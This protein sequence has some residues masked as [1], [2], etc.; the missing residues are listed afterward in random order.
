MF[1][2]NCFLRIVFLI[3]SLNNI[4]NA[5]L[6][7]AKF[8][9]PKYEKSRI[10]FSDYNFDSFNELD[11]FL[12]VKLSLDFVET[13]LQDGI[14]LLSNDLFDQE[15]N[16][17][18]DVWYPSLSLSDNS[19]LYAQ[20]SDEDKSKVIVIGDLHGNYD[21]LSKIIQ[22]L[23][24]R[25]I[26]AQDL[27]IKDGYKIVTLGD[28][29]D[30]GSESLQTVMFLMIL[31]IINPQNYIMLK[32]NHETRK[33]IEDAFECIDMNDKISKKF[34]EHYDFIANVSRTLILNENERLT[35]KNIF[36]DFFDLLPIAYFLKVKDKVFMF[37]HAG[38]SDGFLFVD[39]VLHEFLQ[40][41]L[42][43]AK[44]E[45]DDNSDEIAYRKSLLW[46]DTLPS[47][48]FENKM[49]AKLAEQKKYIEDH[50]LAAKY[51]L[52]KPSKKFSKVD[53]KKEIKKYS[54]VLLDFKKI[55][56]NDG[57]VFDF[58]RNAYL[59]NDK[60]TS[61]LME[62]CGITVRLCGH[63]HALIKSILFPDDLWY[64]SINKITDGFMMMGSR[65]NPVFNLIS[66]EINQGS[67]IV[68][69]N[70]SYLELIVDQKDWYIWGNS[71]SE[72][73]ELFESK[74]VPYCYQL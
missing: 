31:K 4:V 55:S 71:L 7:E 18:N 50:L 38:F 62:N 68:K 64:E 57:L 49:K 59:F 19:F 13:I 47:F 61:Y 43:Y 42:R 26:L 56:I 58:S 63:D 9:D 2:R 51:F 27:V 73:S 74:L 70:P 53:F 33:I 10:V 14:N 21:A 40:S 46:S 12:R 44:I 41:D 5:Q 24:K 22:D 3:L 65:E 28:Y 11:F 29:I 8:V 36:C 52:K 69:Y 17:K 35:I 30:R 54:K 48:I 23:I 37:N 6:I 1:K 34:L 60:H 20:K 15:D 16:L 32:G 45:V 72:G 39:K 66:A 25:K 67:L